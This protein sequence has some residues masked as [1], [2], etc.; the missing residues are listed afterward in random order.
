MRFYVFEV[1]QYI[2]PV[3]GKTET[4]S[5]NGF[6]TERQA[7]STYYQKMATAMKNDNV[8]KEVIGVMDDRGVMIVNPDV[9]E[10]PVEPT[11]EVEES[12]EE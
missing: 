11:S 4:Y 7:K 3:N 5:F 9:Y 10:K 8:S 1:T 12:T 2:E 6:D